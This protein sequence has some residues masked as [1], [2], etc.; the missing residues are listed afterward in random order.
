MTTFDLDG[1]SIDL[2]D[3]DV[4]L[5]QQLAEVPLSFTPQEVTER[6]MGLLDRLNKLVGM[7]LVTCESFATGAVIEHRLT[8]IGRRVVEMGTS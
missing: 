4:Q 2:D 5:L 1:V 6:I 8:I 3:S 7:G